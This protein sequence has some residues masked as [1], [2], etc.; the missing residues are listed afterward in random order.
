MVR[1]DFYKMRTSGNK[2]SLSTITK[3]GIIRNFLTLRL[4]KKMKV[5]VDSLW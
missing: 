1:D 2:Q 3:C 5:N 4:N